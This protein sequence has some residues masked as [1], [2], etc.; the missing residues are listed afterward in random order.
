MSRE[1]KFPV[2]E[3]SIEKYLKEM[4]LFAQERQKNL[5]ASVR[6][7]FETTVKS[8]WYTYMITGLVHFSY[9]VYHQ[10]DE[11]I[12]T[13]HFMKWAG[14]WVR[15]R[16]SLNILQ[17]SIILGLEGRT[18][19]ASNLL[20]PALESIVTGVFFYC[21]SQKG[22]RDKA[23]VLR[24]SD[25]GRKNGE[26]LD[27]ID[28]AID[29]IKDKTAVPV[30]LERQVT[31]IALESDPIL[32]VPRFKTMLKQIIEWDTLGTEDVDLYDFIH[33]TMFGKL[34]TYS[35]SLHETSYARRGL[36]SGRPEIV[37]GWAVDPEA[38]QEY[39]S[40]F[41]LTCIV[42]LLYFLNQTIELQKTRIFSDMITQFFK[43]NPDV[44]SVLGSVA[45]QIR[46]AIE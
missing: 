26:F 25:T 30:E 27:L 6:E 14:L 35:H 2:F 11:E 1:N 43:D 17:D 7:E 21:F 10:R 29:S 34:S 45:D 20:R 33:K 12:F 3:D 24:N 5:L 4:T 8:Y 23:H 36:D 15:L 16:E 46:E 37:F 18:T 39:S 38:F 42:V 9:L 40:Y 31:R 22:Y 44:F 13:Q 28:D 32:P 41:R 19:S